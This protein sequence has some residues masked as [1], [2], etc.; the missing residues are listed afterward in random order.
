[1]QVGCLRWAARA[2]EEVLGCYAIRYSARELVLFSGEVV[3]THQMIGADVY[4]FGPKRYTPV[5]CT[6][7]DLPEI[8]VLIISHNHYDH[9]DFGTIQQL[10]AKQS[11]GK[12]PKIFCALGNKR[13]F[14]DAGIGIVE[15]DVVELDWWKGAR[16]DVEGIGKVELW[17]TPA[18][19][20]SARSGGD[21]NK[22]L[23]CSWVVREVAHAEPTS[24]N[25]TKV[26]TPRSLYFAG[27][28]AYRTVKTDN[29]TPEEEAAAPHCPAFTE[30][31]SIFG[32]FD[33]ALLPI[34]LF[35]PRHI[36][37]PVHCSPEDSACVHRDIKA[38]RSIGMH[39]GTVRG[40][41]SGQYE[42]VRVPPQRWKAACLKE[43][44]KWRGESQNDNEWEAGLCDVGE[45]VVVR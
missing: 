31:G 37:S 22:A 29:P 14:L 9:L 1:M 42:D 28:T 40:G 44:W 36:M 45:T 2:V 15:S 34:G 17:C 20:T 23:W 7:A 21:T 8:D 24:I 26:T 12:K 19:H 16:L 3:G 5:P 18:Q 43:G 6:V 25:A 27:D 13:W 41:L 10:F 38:K 39:Y 11:G 33:L 4:R 30:I 32:P 35:L